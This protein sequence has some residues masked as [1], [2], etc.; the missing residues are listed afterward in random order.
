MGDSPG[1]QVED[2][3]RSS[4]HQDTEG[5][6]EQEGGDGSGQAAKARHSDQNVGDRSE[7]RAEDDR[8]R[9]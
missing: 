6:V 5:D 9:E 7:D 3:L 4:V 1:G 2:E 8:R